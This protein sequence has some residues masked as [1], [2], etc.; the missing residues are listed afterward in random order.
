MLVKRG[1][2]CKVEVNGE[3]VDCILDECATVGV[4]RYQDVADVVNT[5]VK[6]DH[7]SRCEVLYDCDID[8]YVLAMPVVASQSGLCYQPTAYYVCEC[9]ECDSTC[10]VLQEVLKHMADVYVLY[11]RELRALG[12]C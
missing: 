10:E 5:I 2:R 7:D 4:K 6:M 8:W 1:T 12:R 9:S 11:V 3:Y